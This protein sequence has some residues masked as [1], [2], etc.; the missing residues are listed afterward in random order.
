MKI[1]P[2]TY[3][4]SLLAL[5]KGKTQAHIDVGVQEF[6]SML[7]QRGLLRMG[8]AI[9]EL[10]R[11]VVNKA[12]GAS[13]V[14]VACAHALDAHDKKMFEEMIHASYGKKSDISFTV[15]EQ[16]IDGFRMK[17]DDLVVDLSAAGQMHALREH[18]RK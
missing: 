9:L 10:L 8:T 14:T 13:S 1:K 11:E 2:R 5:C 12:A 18:L 15:D 16:L 4:E 6:L 7:A 17:V 3:A